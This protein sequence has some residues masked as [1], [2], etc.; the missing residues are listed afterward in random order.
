MSD[1]ENASSRPIPE[2]VE[3]STDRD[4]SREFAQALSSILTPSEGGEVRFGAQNEPLRLS[5]VE[6]LTAVRDSVGING[7][8]GHI[9]QPG[10]TGKT[11]EGIVA[12]HAM[13]RRGRNTLYV[14]P[15][16]QAVQDFANKARE[17]CPDLDVGTV[18]QVEKH[19]GRLT[20][21][22]YAS[23]LRCILGESVEAE[24]H[25]FEEQESR[26]IQS[27][28]PSSNGRSVTINPAEYDLVIWDEAHKYLTAHAQQLVARFAH[29]IGI[30]LTATP[31][32]YEGKEVAHVFGKGLHEL[33]LRTAV[34]RKEISDFRNL[35]ITTDV[36]TGLEL[37]SPDQEESAA[38]AR[39]ID[40]PTRNRIFPDMYKNAKIRVGDKDFTLTG[41][42]TIV[43]GASINHVHDL[44][45][46]FN[47]TLMEALR[48]DE[49][50]R[51]VLRAKGIDPDQVEQIAAP[52]HSDGTEEH[53]PMS[54]GARNRL[55]ERYHERKVLVLVATSVLQQSFDS[56]I[57][58]V[59]IDSVPRQTYVGVGQAGM[60]ALRY[61]SN[62]EMA[63]IINTQD[64]DHPSLTFLDFQ[65]A[66]GSEEG[67]AVELGKRNGTG[68]RPSRAGGG[69]SAANYNVTY[70]AALVDLAQRRQAQAG[71]LYRDDF[72]TSSRHFTPLGFQRVNQLIVD[73]A[74]GVQGAANTFV[75]VLQPYITRTRERLETQTFGN[76]H[77]DEQVLE[78]AV[79][80]TLMHLIGLVQSGGIQG[81][82][83]FA[84]RFQGD[85]RRRY[86]S[87]QRGQERETVS[88]SLD[89]DV[90]TIQAQTVS[91]LERA[92]GIEE[93]SQVP[94]HEL[95]P[96]RDF[97]EGEQAALRLDR[98]SQR[99][100]EVLRSLTPREREVV[101]MRYGIGHDHVF[102]LEEVAIRYGVTKVRIRQIE[103]RGVLKLRLPLLSRRLEEFVGGGEEEIEVPR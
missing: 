6:A 95:L 53:A 83:R 26:D 7:R 75:Q 73:M 92:V 32:Y 34:E 90:P 4:P 40:L 43:F 10:G 77:I 41:E 100:G 1:L 91:E 88:T 50:F 36:T 48:S 8:I 15:S 67:V 29:T 22:T 74:L 47:D 46:A 66:R 86:E 31:R 51:E 20:F 68:S 57:T 24:A 9:V 27:A 28:E 97:Y 49:E 80:E 101:E 2:V 64:A 12:A 39:A 55:V 87:I 16:Q 94:L 96:S 44:A 18:Y 25:E 89:V 103:V 58:S 76:R 19:I 14:V 61:L 37:S 21:I 98:L 78:D 56:P 70:G 11:R 13:H 54:L 17:L 42:P 52:I 62:K 99:T 69:G 85:L 60:R 79:T 82:S 59:V 30:A 63:F 3:T 65:A 81:W 93:P 84:S 71:Q 102:T 45:Q 23:L 72:E 33:D 35:L 38:V 5:Q